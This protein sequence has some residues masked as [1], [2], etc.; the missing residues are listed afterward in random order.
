VSFDLALPDLII[1]DCDG[2]L[3]DSE[4]ISAEVLIALARPLGLTLTVPYIR[5]HFVG[6]SFPT[7]ARTIR[8]AFGLA[9][10]EDFEARYRAELLAR[11]AAEVKVTPG[12][13]P[14]LDRL[15]VRACV[16]TSSSPAR[17]ARSLAVVGLT[18]RF[19][20]DVFTASEVLRGK[21]APDLFL[22]AADRM[23]VAPARCLV[24]EDSRPG[25]AAAQ[26]AGMAVLL[27]TGGSH[28]GGQGFDTEPPVAALRG[29]ADL[30]ALIPGAFAAASAD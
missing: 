25:V 26:A 12:L 19:G 14:M 10:P 27:Y 5:D 1:F 28:M 3:I 2:V 23:G 8:T 11:F 16:A 6:R 22:H 29:W 18:A 30:P 24:I 4:V 21:P 9:L 7:V 15:R 13:I 20:P 17:V